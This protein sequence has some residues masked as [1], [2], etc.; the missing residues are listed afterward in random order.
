MHLHHVGGGKGGGRIMNVGGV[1]YST[2]MGLGDLQAIFLSD[3]GVSFHM[4]SRR[5]K[6]KFFS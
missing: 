3:S 6:C 1:T 4:Q 5:R 2:D